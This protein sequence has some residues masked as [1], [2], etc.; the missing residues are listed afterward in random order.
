M[1]LHKYILPLVLFVGFAINVQSQQ[2]DTLFRL[3]QKPDLP[4]TV[5]INTN[6]LIS[7]NLSFVDPIKALKYAQEALEISLKIKY[8]KGIADSYR[9]LGSIYSYFGSFYLTVDNLQRAIAGYEELN[10]SSGL[11]NCYISLGHSYRYLKN[12]QKEIEY[13]K[14]SFEIHSRLGNPERIGVT[15][16]NLGESYF[17]NHELGKAINLT[18]LAIHINDSIKNIQVLSSCYKVMGKILMAQ[19]KLDDAEVYF[20]KILLISDSLK[21]KSQKIA[22]IEAYVQLS[23]IAKIKKDGKAEEYYLHKASQFIRTYYLSNYLNSIYLDLIEL[24]VERNQP[25]LALNSISEYKA[26]SDSLNARQTQ[27]KNQLVAGFT[28]V[29]EVEKKNSILEIENK[30]QNEKVRLKNLIIYIS[31]G[32]AIVAIIF[33]ALLYFNWKKVH[34]IN[35]QV[36]QKN[37]IIES[38]N[39]KLEEVNRTKDKFFSIVSHDLRS[40]LNSIS[41]FTD[42]I[43][44][45][46]FTKL[47]HDQFIELAGESKTLIDSTKK[48]T[49]DLIKWAQIQ[50]KREEPHPELVHVWDTANEILE[51]FADHAAKKQI[52]ISSNIGHDLTAFADP[53]QFRFI[54]RNLV[55]NAIKF[56]NIGGTV[57]INGRIN[58]DGMVEIAIN[59]NGVGMSKEKAETIFLVGKNKETRGTAGEASSGLGLILVWEFIQLNKGKIDVTSEAGK[60]TTFTVQLPAKES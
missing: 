51:V 55:N 39:K 26:L 37:M 59:D 25:Q 56:T 10:D 32:F 6:N 14:L 31:I 23:N 4:D 54:I 52:S 21:E 13:H 36:E 34:L 57:S 28:K 5:R 16:H 24:Y 33:L 15:A 50:M 18:T 2:T 41:L 8:K 17:N 60:G 53:N 9:N 42:F 20:K 47:P 48:L 30:L 22:T 1:S 43:V 49:D 38:Q 19:N 3:L 29:Y 27:D 12:I 46:K 35:E 11:A 45:D 40:P 44:S 58:Q 7:R